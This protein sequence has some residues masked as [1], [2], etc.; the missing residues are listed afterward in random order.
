MSYFV[1]KYCRILIHWTVSIFNVCHATPSISILYFITS[2]AIN[3]SL[4]SSPHNVLHVHWYHSIICK[5]TWPHYTSLKSCLSWHRTS[6]LI[7][8]VVHGHCCW[9][10][11]LHVMEYHNLPFHHMQTCIRQVLCSTS[12]HVYSIIYSHGHVIS[13]FLSVSHL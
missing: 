2:T 9:Q 13:A 4:Q 12:V 7:V 10:L 1:N 5:N 8:H 11:Q 6:T 3:H